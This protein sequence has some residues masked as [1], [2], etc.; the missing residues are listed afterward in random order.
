MV[1]LGKQGEA[2]GS[3]ATSTVIDLSVQ[4]FVRCRAIDGWN[5]YQRHHH[6]RLETR[7]SCA[8]RFPIKFRSVSCD[9]HPR[10]DLVHPHM[11]V[12]SMRTLRRCPL[13]LPPNPFNL[14]LRTC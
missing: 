13:C 4:N 3:R 12:L 1:D 2:G 14:K 10:T 11:R 7:L 6:E 8:Q 5:V 9:S